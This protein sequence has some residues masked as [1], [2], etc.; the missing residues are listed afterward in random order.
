MEEIKELGLHK[1]KEVFEKEIIEGNAK[2]YYGSLRSGQKIEHD[3]S[4]V[5]IGEVNAGAE[6]FAT[7][8]IVVVGALRG[9]AHAGAT[10]NTKATISAMGL[11]APQIRI[12]NIVKEMEYV[13]DSKR[14][15]ARVVEGKIII[16]E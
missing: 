6:V 14:Q 11:S 7:E 15:T 5:I 8:N 3:G 2:F 10:G 13:E 1:I 12:A 4:I 16:E 9:V